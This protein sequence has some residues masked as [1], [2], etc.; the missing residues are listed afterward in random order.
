MLEVMVGEKGVL[1]VPVPVPEGMVVFPLEKGNGGLVEDDP[2]LNVPGVLGNV[3]PVPA[4]SDE[5]L[6]KV[7]L[8]VTPVPVPGMLE[9]EL[10]LG[11]G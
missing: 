9:D 8:A 7:G 5:A 4:G 10:P 2:E 6:E 1:P 11:I 3:D